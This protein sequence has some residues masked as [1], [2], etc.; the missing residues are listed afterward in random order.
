MIDFFGSQPHYLNHLEEI[1]RHVPDERKGLLTGSRVEIAPKSMNRDPVVVAGWQDAEDV[2]R[3]GRPIVLTEHGAGQV[4][5]MCKLPNYINGDGR[6]VL[7]GILVLNSQ[8][9]ALSQAAAP[10]VPVA[11]VGSPRMGALARLPLAGLQEDATT[12]TL[13]LA[14]RWDA[15]IYVAGTKTRI[16]EARS[17]WSDW[18]DN[19][20][21][22]AKRV[23]PRWR[24]ALHAHPRATNEIAEFAAANNI[25]YFHSQEQALQA[26]TIWAQDNSSALWEAACLGIPVIHLQASVY[27]KK[28]S[29][30]LRFYNWANQTGPVVHDLA[31]LESAIRMYTENGPTA[32]KFRQGREEFAR[33]HYQF[34]PDHPDEAGRRAAA[35][36]VEW[37]PYVE[38]Q[39][40][41]AL[42]NAVVSRP[43]GA[44]ILMRA[45]RYFLGHEGE[46]WGGNEFY[47]AWYHER[48][49][50]VIVPVRPLGHLHPEV[51]VRELENLGLAIRVSELP[52]GGGDAR[53]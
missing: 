44:K 31:E 2:L 5:T 13:V 12:K 15:Q 19:I 28:V 51:R 24:L 25:V 45:N 10:R 7:G 6:Q 14:F 8:Q 29:H 33:K 49:A 17:G 22:L 18:R 23:P 11:A 4:Y 50:G 1:W 32:N 48:R 9:V 30:G 27:R 41:T 42:K 21:Q 26:A 35:Q 37:F 46:F 3:T 36:V 40:P 53:P 16:Q 39:N 38:P 52:G 43:Q 20:L 34:D 47:A